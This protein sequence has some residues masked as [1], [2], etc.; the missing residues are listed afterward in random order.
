MHS[1]SHT[2]PIPSIYSPF[3]PAIHPRHEAIEHRTSAWAQAHDIGSEQLRAHL[4]QHEIGAFA[5]RILPEGREEV[6]QILADFVIWLFGVDDG[7]CEDGDLGTRPGEL[8]SVLS[9]LLRVAQNPEAP[10]MTGDPLAAGLRDLRRRIDRHATPAQATRWVDALREYFLAVVWEAEHRHQGT[11]PAL[12][13]YVLMRLYDGATTVVM[14]LLEMGH[15]YELTPNERDDKKVRA[16]AEMAY[17]LLCWD[18][19]ILSFHKESRTGRYY[20]N[21]LPVLRQEHGL[22]LSE[23]LTA[24]I[25]QR[26][27]VTCLYLRL[28]DDLLGSASPRLRQYL[29]SLSHFIRAFQDWGISSTRYTCPGDPARLPT[30]FRD[31]PTDDSTDPL[32]IPAISWWWDLLPD[33]DTLTESA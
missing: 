13:D 24:A 20:L 29:T 5:A 7:H 9:R 18:N 19:D 6:V 28:R 12:S 30:R 21:A 16:A 14:P 1:M 4:V 22:S 10:I 17:F 33:T 25:A 15:G 3:S 26:D 11:I 2:L 32:P 27:R 8:A 23:A 31:T